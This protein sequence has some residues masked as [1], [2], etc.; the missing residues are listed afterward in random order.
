MRF[1][2][3]VPLKTPEPS[4]AAIMDMLPNGDD[5]EPMMSPMALPP[6]ACTIRALV[7]GLNL[8]FGCTCSD[9]EKSVVIE[10][11]VGSDVSP[12]CMA[13]CMAMNVIEQRL[14]LSGLQPVRERVEGVVGAAY[15]ECCEACDGQVQM[16]VCV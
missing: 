2:C 11:S 8:E 12:Q 16:D 13:S 6:A 7:E 9:D 10:Q 15:V 14:C 5:E 1:K 3:G 4:P